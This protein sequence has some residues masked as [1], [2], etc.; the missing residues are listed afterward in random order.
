MVDVDVDDDAVGVEDR[1]HVAAGDAGDVVVAVAV[2]GGGLPAVSDV[3][4]D[5]VG[6]AAVG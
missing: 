3:G 4:V 5:S 6:D 1:T 2:L